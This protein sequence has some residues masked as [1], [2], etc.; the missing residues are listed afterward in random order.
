MDHAGLCHR[1]WQE[2][3]PITA[4]RCDVTGQPFPYD[5]GEGVVSAAALADPPPWDRARAAVEFNETSRR[6]V[7]ALKYHDR[8][9]A[10]RLMARM[11]TVAGHDLSSRMRCWRRCRSIAGGCG[12]GASTSRR[13]LARHVAEAAGCG[14]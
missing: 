12:G 13:I 10:G 7:H 2:L 6:L 1:C 4:P 9:E 8:H 14:R 11:M 5:P 3:K